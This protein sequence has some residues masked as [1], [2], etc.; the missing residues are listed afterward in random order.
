LGLVLVKEFMDK[1]NGQLAVKSNL[2][3][4]TK[5]ILTFPKL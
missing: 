3:E 5:F 1:N 4:G 2:D